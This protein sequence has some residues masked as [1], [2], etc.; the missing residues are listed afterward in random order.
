MAK[1]PT[2]CDVCGGSTDGTPSGIKKHEATSKHQLAKRTAGFVGESM[3]AEGAPKGAA[4]PTGTD[5]KG[6]PDADDLR[7]LKVT[8]FDSA[9]EMERALAA[10]PSAF[11]EADEVLSDI[12]AHRSREL[13]RRNADLKW[14]VAN[15]P[16]EAPGYEAEKVTPLRVEV[17]GLMFVRKVLRGSVEK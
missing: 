17:E 12:I 14:R 11:T 4:I 7:V 15:R 9:E 2:K 5:S 3:K 1:N 10:S 13:D 16:A 6:E 8:L